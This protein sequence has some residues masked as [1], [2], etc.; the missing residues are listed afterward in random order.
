MWIGINKSEV[1]F[2]DLDPSMSPDICCDFTR[3]PFADGSISLLIFDPPHLPVAAGTEKSL[4]HF[5]DNYGLSSS[6][7]ADN[8][9]GYFRPFL[10]Q[11]RRVLMKDGLIF[12]KL[13]DFVH[14]HRYQWSL[15]DLICA[16][17]QTEGLT[18]CDLIV[19]K[20]P[21]AGN[22]A[23]GKWKESH[24]ARRSHCYW[25]IV[26]KGKCESKCAVDQSSAKPCDLSQADLFTI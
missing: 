24:H 5:V 13:C 14:N 16:V 25:I 6:L 21:S 15:V 18:A 26:R 22:L 23:S 9:A 17:R 12:V 8:I 19:K 3:L 20:D 7:R 4:R 11:A 1:V 10:E 2:C